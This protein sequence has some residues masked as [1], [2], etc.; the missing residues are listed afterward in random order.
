[1]I[2][3][4]MVAAQ[5]ARDTEALMSLLTEDFVMVSHQQGI[6]RSKSE[7]RSM[8]ATMMASDQ[9]EIQH[10][11]LVYEN[12]DILVEH[13]FMAFADGSKEAILAVWHKRN[14]QLAR[15]ET[16]ATPIPQAK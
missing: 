12:D 15:V 14:G 13:S 9:L 7:F 16:G 11:R 5:N 2:Y 8:V 1:M 6:E 10:Q 4:K 3:P